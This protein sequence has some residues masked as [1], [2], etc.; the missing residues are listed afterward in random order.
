MFL[1]VQAIEDNRSALRFLRPNTTRVSHSETSEGESLK[2]ACM[3]LRMHQKTQCEPSPTIFV[4]D[5]SS[6]KRF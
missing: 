1:H 4:L 2:L 5:F 6:K 3:Y